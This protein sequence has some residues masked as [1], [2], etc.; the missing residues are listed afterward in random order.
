MFAKFRFRGEGGSGKNDHEFRFLGN[1]ELYERPL[2]EFPT[3]NKRH[4]LYQMFFKNVLKRFK[5]VI[6]LI[7]IFTTLLGPPPPLSFVKK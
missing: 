1:I 2:S 6:V 5:N 3:K 4:K 7:G